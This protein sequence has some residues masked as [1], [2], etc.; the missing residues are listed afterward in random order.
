[1]NGELQPA[2][3]GNWFM[4]HYDAQRDLLFTVLRPGAPLNKEGAL[5]FAAW[6]VALVDPEQK[7]FQPLLAAVLKT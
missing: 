5:N 4:V 3:T 2:D 6:T 7:E 1:M